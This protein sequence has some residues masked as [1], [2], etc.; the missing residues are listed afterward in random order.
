MRH[1]KQIKQK[2]VRMEIVAKNDN[3]RIRWKHFALFLSFAKTS[4]NVS[5]IKKKKLMMTPT[6]NILKI[7]TK[8]IVSHSFQETTQ[9]FTQ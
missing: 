6:Y 5:E 9:T 3:R 7:S 8:R 4:S 2:M 1:I